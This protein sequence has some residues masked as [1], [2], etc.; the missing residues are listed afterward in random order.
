M[1]GE[2][3]TNALGSFAAAHASGGER[4]IAHYNAIA[5]MGNV[6]ARRIVLDVGPSEPFQPQVER[7]VAA[8]EAA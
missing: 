4:V 8:V 7:I 6:N 5:A 1:G 2:S 3:M